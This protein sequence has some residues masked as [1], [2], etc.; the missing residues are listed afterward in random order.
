[1]SE[2]PSNQALLRLTSVCSVL[3]LSRNGLKV[4]QDRDPDFPRPI[5]FGTSRQSAVYFDAAEIRQW[6]ELQKLKR[7]VAA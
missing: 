5:K 1:M 3:D 2:I 6:V 7:G 4:L